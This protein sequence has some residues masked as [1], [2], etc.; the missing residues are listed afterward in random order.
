M[1]D[2]LGKLMYVKVAPA[3]EHDS[4]IAKAAFESALFESEMFSNIDL[5][6]ADSAF[7]GSFKEWASEKQIEV[8]VPK[9]YSIQSKE[10]NFYISPRRWVVERSIAWSNNARRLAKDYERKPSISEAFIKWQAIRLAL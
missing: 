7:G 10:G 6:Y 4:K 8:K 3:N 2:T 9:T 5:I 1:T